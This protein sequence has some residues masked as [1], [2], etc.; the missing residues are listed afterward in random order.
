MFS[1]HE[2][3]E[4]C[5]TCSF[6]SNCDSCYDGYYK[7]SSNDCVV[8]PSSCSKCSSNT[9]CSECVVG[10]YKSTAAQCLKCSKQ[11]LSC[12]NN[13]NNCTSCIDPKCNSIS[14]C[15]SCITTHILNDH[16]C[17]PCSKPCYECNTITTTCITCIDNIHQTTP[18]CQCDD[19]YFLN[20]STFMCDQCSFPCLTC[21][22]T[23]TICLSCRSTYTLISNSCTC[24][25]NEFEKNTDPK[26]CQQC[27][28]PCYECSGSQL[29]CSSCI[30][31]LNRHLH[32]HDCICDDTY[33]QDDD[34][35]C[36]LC[37]LPCINCSS[38]STCLS[39]HDSINQIVPLCQCK[40]GYFMDHTSICQPCHHPC[41]SCDI[42]PNQC[43]ECASSF[44]INNYTC[45]CQ[46][47]YYEDVSHNPSICDICNENCKTCSD[48]STFCLSCLDEHQYLNEL[49][50]CICQNGYVLINNICELCAPPCINCQIST[51]YCTSCLDTHHI[52]HDGQCYCAQGWVSD[53]YN[54]CIECQ[55]PCLT[56]S[57]NQ[58][59]CDSCIDINQILDLNFNCI[60]KQQFYAESTNNCIA[61][62]PLCATCNQNGC[63]TCLDT[64]QIVINYQ[65]ICIQGY[66]MNAN[67]D[68]S[69][70]QCQI[71]CLE[72]SI[73][74]NHCLSCVDNTI[75]KLEQNQCICK[76]GFYIH[77]NSC[78]KCSPQCQTCLDNANKCLQCSDI[79]LVFILNECKCQNGSFYDENFQC[80]P[81]SMS[82]YN[83]ISYE[84]CIQ[85]QDLHYLDDNYKCQK[86][87]EHCQQCQN[88]QSCDQCLD[89]YFLF[90]SQCTECQQNCNTCE[91]QSDFCTSCINVYD[92]IDNK[93]QCKQGYY[94]DHFN[95]YQCQFPCGKCTSQTICQECLNIQNVVLD[96]NK[97][98]CKQGYYLSNQEQC[99]ECRYGCKICISSNECIS[100]LIEQNRILQNKVC[101]CNSGYFETE[102]QECQKCNSQ[103][104]KIKE[105]CKYKDCQDNLWTYGEECD[106]GNNIGRDGCTNCKI[107]PNYKCINYILKPSICYKCDTN[108]Y[109]CDYNQN[110]NTTHCIQCEEGYFI[111]QSVCFKC[112]QKCL[113][114]INSAS[115]CVSCR[116]Q[117]NVIGQC[118]NCEDTIG[119]Y[120]DFST[121]TCY[122]K[123]GDGIKSISEEC[124]DGNNFNG[125]GCNHICKLEQLYICQDSIC[126][127]P[128]LPIPIL[129]SIGDQSIYNNIRQFVISYNK[130]LILS[131]DFNLQKHIQLIIRNGQ[132]EIFVDSIFNITQNIELI[133]QSYCNLTVHFQISFNQSIH[134]QEFVIRFTNL[135]NIKS[136]DGYLQQLLLVTTKIA[137][138]IFVETSTI[139]KAEIAS[140]SNQYILYTIG[141]MSAIALLF[142]GLDI[143]YNLLDTIQILSYLKYIN[144]SVPFNLQYF[145]NCFQFVQ[146]NFIQKYFNFE[147]LLNQYLQN[148]NFDT[149]PLKIKQDELTPLFIIN[150][151]SVIF[152]WFTLILI[153]IVSKKIPYYLHQINFKYYDEI[154]NQKPSLILKIKYIILAIKISITRFCIKV[155]REFFCSG[156]YRALISTAYDFTFAIVLQLYSLDLISQNIII[157]TSS[158]LSL[159]SFLFYISIIFHIIKLSSQKQYAF[160]NYQNNLKYGT[161]F[162]GIK[163]SNVSKYFNAIL[164]TKKL[165]FMITLIFFYETPSF[166]I[167]NLIIFTILQS[168]FLLSF[169]PLTD[170]KE[171]V[172]Q[173]SCELNI[174]ITLFLLL[175]ISLNEE[176][177]IFSEDIKSY[178][179]WCCIGSITIIF[180]IQL[181]LDAIQ[182]LIFLLQ[183][184]KK[185]KKFFSNIL[186]LFKPTLL[187]E[188]D[189]NVFMTT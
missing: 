28:S 74:A 53:Q 165:L 17:I 136:I 65:C 30:T 100:C 64:H 35:Q 117:L 2:C 153:Y 115:N 124:D 163:K 180:V 86:C 49:H 102:K 69:C 7:N 26:T 129:Q 87:I 39:C 162:E 55:L 177:R 168:Y 42:N 23:A 99:Q 58:N 120:S 85:C 15:D 127:K 148:E 184:Y 48:L 119:Y 78:H 97:C 132:K 141:T 1:C 19:G 59:H 114:C 13:E 91:N 151:A 150:S 11:C 121:N 175:I 146:I 54:H 79:N 75:Y 41:I 57:V 68:Y 104:G 82:C 130:L 116:F 164:L 92:L 6:Y 133:N 139:Q 109:K 156:I 103:E 93:C 154:P 16:T 3:H 189:H 160:I 107:D 126:I 52:L 5:K 179:G 32:N 158:I 131:D 27:V 138:V 105:N 70:Q 122:S 98:V 83:C 10:Y 166:Q 61:C 33:Y 144:V 186:K 134:N 40:N 45:F 171:F 71:P 187:K 181:I 9:N 182:Q 46:E 143:F 174:A 38:L 88:Q 188:T 169:K 170:Y 12:E 183:K 125:D 128:D 135:T 20:T 18:N 89:G 185:L 14:S 172:K 50:Q 123:C 178:L 113:Q 111:K 137:D 76:D 149:I 118:F 152:L 155:L 21:Q 140:S 167:V 157:R 110:Q 56:C 22:S 95:C 90:N 44:N 101:I 94:N 24:L 176:L 96:D 106:D 31:G 47:G 60:C 81:C 4:S 37:S 25:T 108:C 147:D 43:L 84:H 145:F 29:N 8:C 63:L 112:N 62:N 34:G 72:C 159:I 77:N 80:S 67:D 36:Q 51:N 142:G 161:L 173:F 73:Q 66:Y